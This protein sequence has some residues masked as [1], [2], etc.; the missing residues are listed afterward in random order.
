MDRPRPRALGALVK[1]RPWDLRRVV[2]VMVV[3]ALLTVAAQQAWS[4]RQSGER[5]DDERAA[6]AAAT[7]EVVGLISISGTTSGEDLER[8]VEGAT[9]SFRADLEEQ[10]DRLKASLAKGKVAATGEVVS[11]GVAKIDQE[12]ATVVV[13]ATGTVR[14]KGTAGPEPRHYRLLVELAK[15]GDQWLVSGLEFVA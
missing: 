3:V 9:G 4:W 13:A 6:V 8:L 1:T 12:S 5:A 7:D 10:G 11:A 14:N 2:L 15:E